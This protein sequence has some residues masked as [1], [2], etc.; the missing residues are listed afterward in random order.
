MFVFVLRNFRDAKPCPNCQR[1]VRTERRLKAP[2]HLVCSDG[3]RRA[4]Y[5]RAMLMKRRKTPCLLLVKDAPRVSRRRGAMPNGAR[6]RADSEPIDNAFPKLA[7]NVT[8]AL[9]V[10]DAPHALKAGR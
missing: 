3:C 7:F 2:M 8:P 5:Y 10:P 6:P 1:P 4:I 9:D